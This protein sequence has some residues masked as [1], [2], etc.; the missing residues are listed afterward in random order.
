MLLR[1]HFIHEYIVVKQQ[2][3]RT[4]ATYIVITYFGFPLQFITFIMFHT[5]LYS[6]AGKVNNSEKKNISHLSNK[7]KK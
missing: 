1:Y 7:Y 6:N 2:R 5:S 4:V 3:S